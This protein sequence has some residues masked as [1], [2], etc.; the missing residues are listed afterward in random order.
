MQL[1]GLSK[2]QVQMMQD[3]LTYEPNMNG[4]LT[5]SAMRRDASNSNL[6]HKTEDDLSGASLLNGQSYAGSQKRSDKKEIR[7]YIPFQSKYDM[8]DEAVSEYKTNS[9]QLSDYEACQLSKKPVNMA[10]NFDSYSN[11]IEYLK[12]ACFCDKRN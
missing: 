12:D 3:R 8:F 6:L 9:P 10:Q 7:I 1:Q 4:G 2:S 11:N 5:K